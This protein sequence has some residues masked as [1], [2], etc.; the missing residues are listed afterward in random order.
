MAL[1]ACTGG[2]STFAAIAPKNIGPGGSSGTGSGTSSGSG[3]SGTDSSSTG[4]GSS[5]SSSTTARDFGSTFSTLKSSADAFWSSYGA[6]PS[7]TVAQMPTAGQALYEG[8]VTVSATSTRPEQIIATAHRAGR[9][10]VV[11][12][13]TGAVFSGRLFGF[14][15]ADAAVSTTGE[16]AM[17]GVITANN[18]AGSANGTLT[19]SGPTGSEK[20]TLNTTVAGDLAGS[21]AEV[22]RILGIGPASG[23]VSGTI[24][25]SIYITGDR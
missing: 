10:E 25:N 2:G 20:I 13:F 17:A 5:S 12:N 11:V 18:L 24:T 8:V 9:A 23:P 21:G 16:I 4:S 6:S 3:S 1:T 15:N 7:T 14:T 22:V 19:D